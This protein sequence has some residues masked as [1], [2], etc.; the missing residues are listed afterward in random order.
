MSRSSNQL[1]I[2]KYGLLEPSNWGPDCEQELFLMNKLWN[3]LVE[4]H[5]QAQ[6]DYLSIIMN[7]LDFAEA[8]DKLRKFS[9]SLAAVSKGELQ[10]SISTGPIQVPLTR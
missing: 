10:T 6:Q 7:D 4:I 5:R 2:R 3:C 8:T 1:I 9:E